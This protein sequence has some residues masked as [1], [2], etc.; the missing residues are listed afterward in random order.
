LI[1]SFALKYHGETVSLIKDNRCDPQA[2]ARRF[3]AI[4]EQIKRIEDISNGQLDISKELLKY[5]P[6]ISGS[7]YCDYTGAF[8]CLQSMAIEGFQDFIRK[9]GVISSLVSAGKQSTEVQDGY[10]RECEIIREHYRSRQADEFALREGAHA[11]KRVEDLKKMMECLDHLQGPGDELRKACQEGLEKLRADAV[12][13]I[14]TR[15]KRAEKLLGMI[16]SDRALLTQQKDAVVAMQKTQVD[17]GLMSPGGPMGA[18]VTHLKETTVRRLRDLRDLE[19]EYE[20]SVVILKVLVDVVNS[21]AGAVRGHMAQMLKNVEG[22]KDQLVRDLCGLTMETFIYYTDM[23]A[24]LDNQKVVLENRREQLDD[25]LEE[26]MFSG[27]NASDIQDRISS[28]EN[29]LRE[30]GLKLEENSTRKAAAWHI[31]DRLKKEYGCILPTEPDVAAWKRANESYWVIERV[32]ST[33]SIASSMGKLAIMD[34][35]EG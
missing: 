7:K 25:V 10:R 26:A 12:E 31:M 29:A 34:V 6:Q 32:R 16:R 24:R 4:L 13:R 35:K 9:N 28:N 30:L 8:D 5:N 1:G 20:H 15:Q 18:Y 19:K 23:H 27:V 2:N 11:A 33:R 21:G 22:A 3:E 17:A 14:H